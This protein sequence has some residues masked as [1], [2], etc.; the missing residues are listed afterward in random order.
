[1][2][3]I[4]KINESTYTIEDDGVR[5]FLLIG[6]TKALTIDTG[7]NSSNAIKI[8]KTLTNKPIELLNTHCDIDHIS[9]NE[10]FFDIYMSKE[11]WDYYQ[12]IRKNKVNIHIVKEND[13]I[14]LGNRPLKIVNLNGHTQGSIGIIDINN[15]VL[16]SGDSI[17]DGK[18]FMFGKRRNMNLYIK[19]LEDLI[20]K[21]SDEY[22]TIYPS[23]GSLPVNPEIVNKLIVGAK[24]I[25]EGQV[26][27]SSTKVMGNNIIYYDLKFAGFL[28]DK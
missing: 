4:V 6:E 11:E 27:G 17:Q 10:K 23:H 24:K 19:T 9:G 21:Y 14:D 1:M 8:V 22:D 20:N 3:E 13:V 7:M 28:L 15:R 12:I 2:Q 26:Q 5:F 16:I 25:L 18:I